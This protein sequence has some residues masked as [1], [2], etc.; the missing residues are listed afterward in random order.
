MFLYREHGVKN[1]L[2]VGGDPWTRDSLSLFFQ[3]EGCRLRS[4]AG[5]KEAIAALEGDRFDMILCEHSLPDMD[6]L[7]LLKRYG[8][9]QAGAVRFLISSYPTRSL[10]EEAGRHGIHDVIRKP[11]TIETLENSLMRCLERSR[12]RDREPVDVQ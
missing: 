1:I 8:N 11:I 12:G 7:D 6:G 9:R 2:L 10:I 5:A 3:I 4:A